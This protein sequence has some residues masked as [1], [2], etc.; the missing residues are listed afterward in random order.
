MLIQQ[1]TK[2]HFCY[3]QMATKAAKLSGNPRV[4][5]HVLATSSVSSYVCSYRKQGS[6]Q[7]PEKRC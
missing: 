7:E 4:A 1:S 2:S 5:V 3:E 6:Y